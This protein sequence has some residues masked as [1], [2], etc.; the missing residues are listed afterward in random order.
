MQ[1]KLNPNV[2][3]RSQPYF[4]AEIGVNYE[5]NLK[6]QKIIK[7]ARGWRCAVKF[8]SYKAEKIACKE[9]PYYWDL[10]KSQ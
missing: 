1:F 6:E 4:I 5:N 10:K 8:Q 9:S 3:E 7:L 2:S